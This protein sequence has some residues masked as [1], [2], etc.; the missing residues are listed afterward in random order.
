MPLGTV[1]GLSP[2]DIVLDGDLAPLTER[3]AAA[4]HFLVL[5]YCDQTVAHVS[6]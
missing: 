6:S 2:G 4:L 5:V 1:V 3:G